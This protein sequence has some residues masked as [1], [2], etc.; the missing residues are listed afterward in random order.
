MRQ[1]SDSKRKPVRWTAA[2]YELGS[3][4]VS[5]V[6]SP[7]FMAWTEDTPLSGRAEECDIG[8]TRIAIQTP[9]FR[10]PEYET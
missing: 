7:S 6:G 2:S 10:F 4:T 3:Y 8:K 1:K 5:D 9:G